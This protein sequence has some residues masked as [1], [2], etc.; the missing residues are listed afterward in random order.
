MKL[1]S[2]ESHLTCIGRTF[3]GFL[4]FPKK[5]AETAEESSFIGSWS[6]CPSQCECFKDVHESDMYRELIMP[7]WDV[8]LL[9]G[10]AL[11]LIDQKMY[12]SFEC[13][14]NDLDASV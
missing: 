7:L 6:P 12:F 11:R 8:V 2:D 10:T 1:S 3:R 5:I 13:I 4:G 14:V 9:S